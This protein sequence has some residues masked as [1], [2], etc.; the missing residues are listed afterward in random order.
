MGAAAIEVE[1][2]SRQTIK[3][4]SPTPQYLRNMKLSF[5]DQTAPVMYTALLLFYNNANNHH[6]QIKSSSQIS[7]HLKSSLSTM[8]SR[9][10]PLAG[11]IIDQ[12]T[13]DCD[14]AGAQ[15]VEARVNCLLSD[16]LQQ[17]DSLLFRN[18]LPV[19]IESTEAEAGRVLFVQAN[20]F[21]CGGMVIGLC[22]SHKIAD[23][24]TI[25]TVVKGWSAAA[26]Q[27]K[28][29][30][31]EVCFPATSIFPPVNTYIPPMKLV[32]DKY[33]TTDKEV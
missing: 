31:V 24:A 12:T 7:H 30:A 29:A 15:F 20:F 32:R 28:E 10:Y 11:T 17:S 27:S 9:F 14:D 26:L 3:P 22:I 13:I 1:I 21:H 18:F 16:I 8:L 5:I 19:E 23:V 33:V 4:S 6:H 25:S 2:I